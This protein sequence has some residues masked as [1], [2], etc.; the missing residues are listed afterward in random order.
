[1]AR[2]DAALT[3]LEERVL[4]ELL[5]VPSAMEDFVP[6]GTHRLGKRFGVRHERVRETVL[7]LEESGLIE[8]DFKGKCIGGAKVTEKG[9]M[10]ALGDSRK[11]IMSQPDGRGKL[12]TRTGG[13]TF[14][15]GTYEM[16]NGKMNRKRFR[17]EDTGRAKE[18]YADW[19]R[20]QSEELG[21]EMKERVRP[22]PRK[23]TA[24]NAE[25][26][27]GGKS[28]SGNDGGGK[29]KEA[30]MEK[31]ESMD[32]IYT[33]QVVG[34]ASIA[35]TESFDK[36]VAVCDALTLAAKA[37]GF[38]AKYDVVEVKRWTA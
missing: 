19:C 7:S 30:E 1:M 11:P 34:G 14:W 33:I 17:A 10:S 35:W 27:A 22:K 32:K 3:D 2:G 21:R 18:L 37:S 16:P 38:A 23:E 31:D 20:E 24:G 4:T 26:T 6:V 13:G 5:L 25:S 28:V 9:R 29:R 36:A 15:E 12:Y 8:V